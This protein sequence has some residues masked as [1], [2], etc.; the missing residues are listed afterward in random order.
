MAKVKSKPAKREVALKSGWWVAVTLKPG[1]APLRSYVGCIQEMDAQGLRLTL[2]DWFTGVAGGWDLYIPHSNLE[3]ALVATDA[4][5]VESFR[6]ASAKWQNKMNGQE[7]EKAYGE[8][9]ETAK[10]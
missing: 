2:V 1:T 3:S 7:K 9:A 10:K 6:E 5:D 4:H 8:G